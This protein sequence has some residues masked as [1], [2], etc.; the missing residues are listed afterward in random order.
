MP[1]INSSD[2]LNHPPP[3]QPIPIDPAPRKLHRPSATM[4]PLTPIEIANTT[5]C[6]KNNKASREDDLPAEIYKMATG[7]IET[8]L[9]PIFGR[10][11]YMEFLPTDWS[12]FGNS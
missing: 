4:K 2:P 1:R 7:V 12:R 11:W 3:S 8:G 10:V 5:K 9:V 6:L